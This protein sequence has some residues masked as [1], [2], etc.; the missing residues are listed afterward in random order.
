LLKDL[1]EATQLQTKLSS[2]KTATTQAMNK[3]IEGSIAK[4][5]TIH[6]SLSELEASKADATEVN[7]WVSN[8]SVIVR[9]YQDHA[10]M[11]TSVLRS[12]D[13]K[14]PKPK[15]ARTSKPASEAGA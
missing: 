14:S 9:A 11:A 13:R 15:K 7:A 2:T 12:L 5:R 8:A 10:K 1:G 4:L 6:T 3:D